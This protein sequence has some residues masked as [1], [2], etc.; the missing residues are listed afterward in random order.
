MTNSSQPYAIV[1]LPDIELEAQIRCARRRLV[2]IAPGLSESVAR[3]IVDQWPTLGPNAVQ[4]V[5]DPDPEVCRLGLGDLAALK[6]LHDTAE[7][8]GGRIHQQQG[9][10]VGVVVTDETTTVY[11]PTPRLIEAG[12][13]P[14]E[15]QNALRF[16]TPIL[17]PESTATDSELRSI[18][19][20]TKPM[21]HADVQKTTQDLDANPPVKFDLA[22]K[23]RVF[24]ARFEFVEF[25]LHEQVLYNFCSDGICTDGEGPFGGLVFDNAGSLYGATQFGGVEGCNFGC[26]VVFELTVNSHGTWKEKLLHQFSSVKDGYNTLAALIFDG[27][28]DLYGTTSAGGVFGSGTVFELIPDQRGKWKHKILRSFTGGADGGEPASELAFDGAGNLYGTTAKGGD[29]TVCN[30]A[31]CGVV[32]KLTQKADRIWFE[33]LLHRFHDRPGAEPV[34]GVVLD[35]AGNL[36]G[37]T[38]G[39]GSS[40]EGS[41]YQ[42]IF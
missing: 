17:S 28:G 36:Y 3:A 7:R 19:L 6:M 1:S 40:S 5:L 31:G 33:T 34:A 26:G 12:G 4:V 9:L 25:E 11:S 8:I 35:A 16:D 22:R 20:H 29:L 2:V 37:T 18:D 10:R 42:I 21:T 30:L 38:Q 14:G 27:A 23:V 41:V 15:R 24:N 32:F 39:D 13:K